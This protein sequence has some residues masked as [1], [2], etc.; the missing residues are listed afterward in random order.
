MRRNM[1]RQLLQTHILISKILNGYEYYKEDGTDPTENF[2][3]AQ[4]DP[5]KLNSRVTDYCVVC[6]CHFML[7]PTLG[8]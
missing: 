4:R 6:G 1:A 3:V 8:F 5:E 2:V 7:H